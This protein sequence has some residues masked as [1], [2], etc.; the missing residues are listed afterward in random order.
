MKFP[1]CQLLKTSPYL[2]LQYHF[3]NNSI[4]LNF[5]P[6]LDIPALSIRI[7]CFLLLLIIGH[8]RYEKSKWYICVQIEFVF[9]GTIFV[10]IAILDGITT[11]SFQTMRTLCVSWPTECMALFGVQPTHSGNLRRPSRLLLVR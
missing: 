2:I 1:I 6:F 4:F 5:Q 7:A 8:A 9:L 3:P 11:K 10:R